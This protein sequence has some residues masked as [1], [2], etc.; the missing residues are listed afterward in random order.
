MEM[1]INMPI[2]PNSGVAIRRAWWLVGVGSLTTC[3]KNILNGFV[4]SDRMLSILIGDN[5]ILK[6][7]KDGKLVLTGQKLNTFENYQK[8]LETLVWRLKGTKVKS[9]W[10]STTHVPVD[11]KERIS[12][13]ATKYNQAAKR[14][15]QR[16]GIPVNNLFKHIHPN[17]KQHQMAQNFLLKKLLKKYYSSLIWN[18]AQIWI[19]QKNTDNQSAFFLAEMTWYIFFLYLL[20]YL[21]NGMDIY[22]VADW[23]K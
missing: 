6:Y 14:V 18:S 16:N 2:I 4:V 7:C 3:Q 15:K 13:D 9:I 10:A 21:L 19:W 1:G 5:M 11:S 12:G 17:L 8:N 23:H 20:C 22:N